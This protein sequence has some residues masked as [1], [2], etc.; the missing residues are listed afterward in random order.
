MIYLTPKIDAAKNIIYNS[1][2][3]DVVK[4]GD[5]GTIIPQSTGNTT[6]HVESFI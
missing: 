5:N 3:K 4:M 2:N 6:I 1:N